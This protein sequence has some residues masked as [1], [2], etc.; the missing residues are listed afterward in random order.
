VATRLGPLASGKL[1]RVVRPLNDRLAAA[2]GVRVVSATRI[3]VPIN[4]EWVRRFRYFDRLFERVGNV[5]GAIVECGVAGGQSLAMLASL[6]RERDDSRTIWG[7]DSWAGLP[8]PDPADIDSETS[9]AAAGMFAWAGRSLVW[10]ELEAHGFSRAEIDARVRLV[11]G[12]FAETLPA[13]DDG[14]IALLHVDADLY[15][16]YLTVLEHLWQHV[17]PGGIV[18]LDEYGQVAWPGATRAV[19]EFLA[20]ED[21]HSELRHDQAAGKSY[22]VK[23]S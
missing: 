4:A 12:D 13:Y 5:P 9:Y 15:R 23:L 2:L 17:A 19:D 10:N 8:A 21:V 1:R 22:A 3:G 11:K 16:S 6:L 18:A 7:F 20:R 14:P